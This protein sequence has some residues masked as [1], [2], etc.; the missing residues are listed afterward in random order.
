[1]QCEL[2]RKIVA[3][4]G[5]VVFAQQVRMHH[6]VDGQRQRILGIDVQRAVDAVEGRGGFLPEVLEP[7]LRDTEDVSAHDVCN[8][9]DLSETNQR[10]LLHRGRARIRRALD[11]YVRNGARPPS[12]GRERCRDRHRLPRRKRTRGALSRSPKKTSCARCDRES[13]A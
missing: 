5:D 6:A 9:L 8:I 7:T 11:R 3:A 10:V 2:Q 12:P 13:S 1:M 4:L